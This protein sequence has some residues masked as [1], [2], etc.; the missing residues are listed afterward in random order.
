MEVTAEFLESALQSLKEEIF[1][2]LHVAMPGILQSYDPE[3]QTATVQPA[4]QRRSA[5][6]ETISAPLLH[7]VPVFRCNSA[8]DPAPGASCLLIFAD[9]CIDGWLETGELSPP[10]SPRSHDLSDAFVFIR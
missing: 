6:G 7:D 3:T 9:F 10:A 2:S 8:T 5:T 4:L 1:S